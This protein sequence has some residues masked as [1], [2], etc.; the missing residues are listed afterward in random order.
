MVD[1]KHSDSP[2]KKLTKEEI[3]AAANTSLI[4][5][6][7]SVG[8]PVKR[9]GSSIKWVG[10]GN[11][12]VFIIPQSPHMF[13]HF[14]TGETGNAIKFCQTKL[15]MGFQEAV[16]ALNGSNSA[17][18][19]ADAKGKRGGKTKGPFVMPRRSADQTKAYKY[20]SEE[21]GIHKDVLDYFIARG[22]I[23]GTEPYSNIAFLYK[24]FNGNFAGA[25]K[26]GFPPNNF[27]GNHEN[28]NIAQYCFRHEAQTP[29][30]SQRGP[31]HLFVFEAPID[32]LSYI[33][34]IEQ[35]SRHNW[36]TSSYLATGG[37]H[38]SAGIKYIEHMIK[39]AKPPSTIYLCQ[40]NDKAGMDARLNMI[41]GL[42]K[43]GYTG[44]IKCHYSENKDWN[45]DLKCSII[46][47]DAQCGKLENGT[48]D[49]LAGG[50]FARKTAFEQ[51]PAEPPATQKPHQNPMQNL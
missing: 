48:L 26:R 22:D 38:A 34:M 41:R 39:A 42:V 19:F 33:S 10:R 51:P 14:S 50:I 36:Q 30:A 47:K 45:M 28:S 7:A 6:L 27:K 12:S 37:I 35:S 13:K 23:Y 46:S 2:Y 9:V 3:E 18:S 4:D 43:L 32:M 20:L 15:G 25:I 31:G 44:N 16:K 5:F 49:A 1:I 8:E 11:D 24:D 29:T 17:S 40:D 21:R